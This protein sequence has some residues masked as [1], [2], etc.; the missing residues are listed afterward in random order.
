MFR[1]NVLALSCAIVFVS[2]AHGQTFVSQAS[3]NDTNSCTRALP[4]K[5]FQRAV[6]LT[7]AWG[8]LSVLDPGDYGAV[9]ISAAITIDGNGLVNNEATSGDEIVVSAPAGAVVQLRNMTI[10]GNGG[11]VFGINFAS[12]QQLV[13]ENMK[14]NGFNNDC[15]VVQSSTS[16][17]DV[18]INDTSIDNCSGAGIAINNST[19]TI[20]MEVINSHVHFANIGIYAA[21]QGL[22][23]VSNSTFSSPQN[24]GGH[25]IWNASDWT[26][27]I[28]LDNCTFTNWQY[29]I[30]NMSGIVQTNR[31]TFNNNTYVLTNATGQLISNGNNSFANNGTIGSF[32]SI[33]SLQ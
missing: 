20:T 11:G 9:T 1:K 23:S 19:G 12:G 7:P 28:M 22:I 2:A 25:G 27:T 14:V 16:N 24:G 33:V 6:N 5:T 10:H 3:G 8:Q 18:V 13:V 15:I 26:P 29:A 31:G 21:V 17:S 32:T 4:C 30:Y